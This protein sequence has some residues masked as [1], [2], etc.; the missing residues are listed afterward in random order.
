MDEQPKR[1]RGRPKGSKNKRTLGRE[2]VSS[3][4]EENKH[5]AE[6][7]QAHAPKPVAAFNEDLTPII[8]LRQ[9]MEYYYCGQ[10]AIDAKEVFEAAKVAHETAKQDGNK[11]EIRLTADRMF[12]AYKVLLSIRDKA[13]AIADRAAPYD[14]KN[15]KVSAVVAPPDEAPPEEQGDPHK[16]RLEHMATRYGLTKKEEAA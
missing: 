14:P 10:A 7:G 13:V 16:D 2:L 5:R 12:D 4:M 1:K 9:S 15:P 8:V 3:R 11:V 6:N